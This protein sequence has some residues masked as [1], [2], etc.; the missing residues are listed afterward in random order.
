MD[1]SNIHLK[2]IAEPM[3]R[4]DLTSAD[5]FKSGNYTDPRV[6][7][8]LQT[9]QKYAGLG[10]IGK[11]DEA[12]EGLRQ[13][14]HQEA[15]F[16][17]AVSYW[18]D[19]NELEAAR[20]LGSI[21]TQHARNL[22]AFIKKPVIE[23]L[24]QLP[25]KRHPPQDLLTPSAGDPKFRVRNI[26]SHPD[27]L[28]I[29]PYADIHWYYD[30]V[31][32]PDFYICEMA[33][34]HL[35]PP[36]ILELPCPVLGQTADYDIHIQTVYPWLGC[37]DELVVTDHTEWRDVSS[38]VDIPVSTFP[39]SFGILDHMP[40]IRKASRSIDLFMSGTVMH[41]YNPDKARLLH[42]LLR[43]PDIR[44]R[45]INGFICLEDYY[46]ALA[47]AKISLSYVRRPGSTPTRILEALAMG[48][49]ALVQK[50]SVISLFADENQGVCT[51]EFENN[52]LALPIKRILA[53]WPEFE[54]RA[55]QGAATIRRHFGLS[56][57]ASQY[58][59][60]MTFLAAKPRER[61]RAVQPEKFRQKRPV[62]CKGWLPETSQDLE[63][64]LDHNRIRWE[65]EL[66]SKPEL[67][68]FIDMARELVLEHAVKQNGA[69]ALS[70]QPGL[71]KILRDAFDLY[72][73]GIEAFPRSLVLRFN[74]IR[75]AFHFGCPHDVTEALELLQATVSAP[76][77]TWKIDV[78]EDVFPWDFFPKL[79]NYRQYFDLV[80]EH[81][82][83]GEV[84][85]DR[86]VE[87]IL[88]SLYNY[89]GYYSGSP[90]H[91][92]KAVGLDPDFA[93]YS[94]NY[95]K[96]L[97]EVAP[98]SGDY[99]KA[100]EILVDLT[101]TSIAYVESY[102]ILRR[103]IEQGLYS[104]PRLK[105]I[106]HLRF[107]E[108]K[109]LQIEHLLPD[110]L[111]SPL[112][113][114]SNF[115]NGG[116]FHQQ[117]RRTA[118]ISSRKPK[119]LFLCT[120]STTWMGA[121]SNWSY[122][123]Q[124]GL[125]EGFAAS[126]V[127]YFTVPGFHQ[128]A[129][130]SFGSWFESARAICA[131]RSFDQVWIELAHGSYDA[132][133][134][135]WI[136][137]LAPVRV[138]LLAES[139][140][141]YPDVCTHYPQVADRRQS[142]VDERLRYMTHAL[143]EDEK[144]AEA[145]KDTCLVR[146]MWWVQAVPRRFVCKQLPR[147]WSKTAALHGAVYS[148]GNQ[149]LDNKALSSL[150]AP[151]LTPAPNTGLP[152][153]FDELNELFAR[154]LLVDKAYGPA[155]SDYLASLRSI[156]SQSFRLWI[157]GLQA[158]CAI[159]NMPHF[160]MAYLGRIAEAMAAGRPV[161]TWDIP[162]RRGNRALFEEGKEILFYSNQSQLAEHI[163]RL[164]KDPGLAWRIAS[165][166][167]AKVLHL[168]TIEKRVEQ[169]LSWIEAGVEPCYHEETADSLPRGLSS[170][171]HC[172]RPP[173]HVPIR[174]F[175]GLNEEFQESIDPREVSELRIDHRFSVWLSG[176]LIAKA[177]DQK[178][179]DLP[180]LCR[181]YK[182]RPLMLAYRLACRLAIPIARNI[183]RRNL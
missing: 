86:L 22:L 62:L 161:I 51:Y 135:D 41:P 44:L 50:G 160:V 151:V 137:G 144:D 116:N 180:R 179:N 30:S 96:K 110:N 3:L 84:V 122:T 64:L 181:K 152:R 159:V 4:P 42:Q 76:V 63:E 29:H 47:N 90:E 58:L 142:L 79:F 8:G 20:L 26:S 124:L 143:A 59:R 24:A 65:Q 109:V 118:S 10:L 89:L 113:P 129:P 99:A 117:P 81:L 28:K 25:W 19:G 11:S 31:T 105:E 78:M 57:V 134:L 85:K 15:R 34:W 155:F 154:R 5:L 45:L 171:F 158:G 140:R 167:R 52:D 54:R 106:D 23:V 145:I 46:K 107:A 80:T 172:N 87:L 68:T 82:K 123:A 182:D 98:E 138:G 112:T 136:S 120:E 150:F 88:S 169:I 2:G 18:I 133:F 37:F 132:D 70:S 56:R 36:N 175:L 153:Q 93:F 6:M 176:R 92:G 43:I 1:S 13:F 102:D 121:P 91:F 103:L 101:K 60:F 127:D 95:A 165:N 94:L 100:A 71:D 74:F 125:E 130:S 67:N 139:L 141:F 77:E 17:R 157:E 173:I 178:L 148:D 61:S 49:C 149:W 156:R 39:K 69:S 33:E 111:R 38:L 21:P 75:S 73:Q 114:I 66:V 115:S 128:I 147:G 14:D 7:E 27:D 48:C 32:P 170:C 163:R 72:R 9:W 162:E 183:F 119:I 40:P 53:Y 55:V 16:Y 126:G 104:G 177:Q 166:A 168:H 12:I 174:N 97:I 83:L 35:I 164:Q 108:E 146:A 131:G